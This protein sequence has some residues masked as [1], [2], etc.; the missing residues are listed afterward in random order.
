MPLTSGK[1]LRITNAFLSHRPFLTCET[2]FKYKTISNRIMPKS[3]RATAPGFLLRHARARPQQ[4][5]QP[6]P[7]QKGQSGN[8]AGRPRGSRNRPRARAKPAGREGGGCCAQSHRDGASRQH[9]RITHVY[10]PHRAGAKIRARQLRASAARESRRYGKSDGDDCGGGS[11][12]RSCPLRGHQHGQ[13]G[14]DLHSRA[15][16]KSIPLRCHSGAA[17]VP[18]APE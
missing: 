15:R 3:G 17:R 8:P 11:D 4:E 12:R 2:P 9:S 13:G 18:S 5:E 7:F 14:R 10:G 16:G 6:M 1:R